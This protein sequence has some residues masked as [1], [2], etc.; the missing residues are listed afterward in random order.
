MR[1]PLLLIIGTIAVVGAD[2]T[3]E[4]ARNRQDRTAL[5][6]V[7]AA[8]A[9][10]A[11][12]AAGHYEAALAYSYLSEVALELRDKRQARSAAEVGITEAK[13]AIGAEPGNAEYHRLLGTLCGQVI[14]ADPMAGFQ[15]GRC[16]KEEVEK[17]L[18]M[19]PKSAL[20]WMSSG[21]GKFYLPA[22][23]GGGVDLAMKEFQ[24]A[25]SLDPK[26]AEGWLWI[27]LAYRKGNRI[28]EARQALQKA[29][30]LNPERI[31][32]QQQLEKTPAQ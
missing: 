9:K 31:W 12:N 16:A 27:G 3:L 7:G 2:A 29:K 25:V 20:A 23:F 18:Q 14:P 4:T 11:K 30:S 6:R 28:A 21:V 22:M 5:E 24:K 19:N 15:H 17:A 1:G 26:L 8:K 13:A 32:I 10:S